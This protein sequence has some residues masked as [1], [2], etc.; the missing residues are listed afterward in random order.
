MTLVDAEHKQAIARAF[1]RA[2]VGYDRFA[3]VQR[4]SGERLMTL[5]GMRDG[6]D[7]LDAG[8]GTGVLRPLLAVAG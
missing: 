4:A 6:D 5:V 8:C 2:A 3:D 1:G 7:V